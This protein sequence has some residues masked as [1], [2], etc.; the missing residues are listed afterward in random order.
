M[1]KQCCVLIRPAKP[2][3]RMFF[4]SYESILSTAG[5]ETRNGGKQKPHII[6]L[7]RNEIL[8][9][10]ISSFLA[11]NSF[12]TMRSSSF[13][14]TVALALVLMIL[15]IVAALPVDTPIAAASP[16]ADNCYGSCTG[17]YVCLPY[18][19]RERCICPGTA[20]ESN[21]PYGCKFSPIDCVDHGDPP[22]PPD[23]DDD[24]DSTTGISV[25][26]IFL[27]P[28]GIFSPISFVY[29]DCGREP[30]W[31]DFVAI[32]AVVGVVIYAVVKDK[33]KKVD[34]DLVVTTS[35]FKEIPVASPAETTS[36]SSNEF[37]V[38]ASQSL[39]ASPY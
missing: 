38:A 1:E 26:A 27:I 11:N 15:P 14:T 36:S 5:S 9:H 19:S 18:Y 33:R 22:D 29:Y 4:S 28:L 31:V 24:E 30:L 12:E 16:A 35:S 32:T 10:A 23:P 21:C 3:S 37:L 8:S 39:I 25:W 6:F 2:E 17:D 7:G 20:L 13:G 34:E